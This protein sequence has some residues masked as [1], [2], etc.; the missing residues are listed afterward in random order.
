MEYENDYSLRV[1]CFMAK[2]QKTNHKM[3]ETPVHK[4]GQQVQFIIKN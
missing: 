3:E 2:Q 1:I 4:W